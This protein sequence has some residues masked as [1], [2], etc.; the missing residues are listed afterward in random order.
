MVKCGQNGVI[1]LHHIFVRQKSVT[2]PWGEQG[3]LRRSVDQYGLGQVGQMNSA[4]SALDHRCRV[5]EYRQCSKLSVIR[6]MGIAV[7][8]R[9]HWFFCRLIIPDNDAR[10]IAPDSPGDHQARD[11]HIRSG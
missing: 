2:A 8:Y 3:L 10:M 1:C 9:L 5:S 7:G 6:R 4:F 11:A